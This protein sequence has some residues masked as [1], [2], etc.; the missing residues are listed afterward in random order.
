MT[1]NI[2]ELHVP[3][4]ELILDII[5]VFRNRND[6]EKTLLEGLPRWTVVQ[7]RDG[8][9]VFGDEDFAAV[10]KALAK[11]FENLSTLSIKTSVIVNLKYSR[12]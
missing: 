4:E 10:K 6:D 12:S 3:K 7:D 8:F 2:D 5:F 9:D 1:N 11:R